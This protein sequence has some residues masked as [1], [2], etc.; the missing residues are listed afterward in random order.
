MHYK[1]CIPIVEDQKWFAEA[2]VLTA[3][4][5]NLY[6]ICEGNDEHYRQQI[7]NNILPSFY[8]AI[9]DVFVSVDDNAVEDLKGLLSS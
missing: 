8:A 6:I 5:T 4:R 1:K 3:G 2:Y 9:G 7:I